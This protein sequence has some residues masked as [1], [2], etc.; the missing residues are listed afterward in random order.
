MA[1]GV[2]GRGHGEEA[3]AGPSAPAGPASAPAGSPAPARRAAGEREKRRAGEGRGPR[4]GGLAGR[5]PGARE[6]GCR[7]PGRGRGRPRPPRAPPL[8]GRADSSRTD[9]CGPNCPKQGSARREPPHAAARGR[10]GE[11]PGGESAQCHP[12][13][14]PQ[15]I[16]LYNRPNNSDFSLSPGSR[17]GK[18]GLPVPS[19]FP[20]APA[21]ARG[22]VHNWASSIG[23]AVRG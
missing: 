15:R 19:P 9:F 17:H 10:R 18:L 16:A 3:A 12:S 11:P 8:S 21:T 5:G 14:T 13:P 6:V 1:A 23:S 7:G 4:P 2:A 22:S 20:P